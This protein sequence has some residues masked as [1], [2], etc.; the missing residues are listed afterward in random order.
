M[1]P[2]W[3]SNFFVLAIDTLELD[4]HSSLF[5]QM[6]HYKLTIIIYY[7]FASDAAAA[8]PKLQLLPRTV[9][10]PVNT[11]VHS[12]KNASIFGTGKPRDEREFRLLTFSQFPDRRQT[13]TIVKLHLLSVSQANSLSKDT[14]PSD[15]KD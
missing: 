14:P 9:K 15:N 6:A 11:V 2:D 8:R 1:D 7:Y 12:E 4:T 10:D 3:F 13:I 5:M